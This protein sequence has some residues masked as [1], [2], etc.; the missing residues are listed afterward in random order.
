MKQMPELKGKP[1]PK[2]R[3]KPAIGA[4]LAAVCASVRRR[5]LERSMTL[6]HLAE[7][8]ELTPNYIGTIETGQRDPSLTTIEALTVGLA[9]SVSEL[10]GAPQALS[11]E[12]M[13]MAQ[14]FDEIEEDAQRGLLLLLHSAVKAPHT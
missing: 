2:L 7:L 8:S 9:I 5:R 3:P 1:K 6:E 11:P 13:E 10:F 12:A 14:L 4:D